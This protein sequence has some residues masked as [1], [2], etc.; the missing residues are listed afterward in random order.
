MQRESQANSQSQT[1]NQSWLYRLVNSEIPDIPD[2]FGWMER[3]FLVGFIILFTF[4]FVQTYP[5]IFLGFGLGDEFDWSLIFSFFEEVRAESPLLF[6]AALFALAANLLFRM[7]L[8]LRGQLAYGSNDPALPMKTIALYMLANSL[9]LLFIFLTVSLLGLLAVWLG[10][11]F[12]LGFHAVQNLFNLAMQHADQIPTVV[13][14]PLLIAFF[15]TYMVQGFFHYWIHRLC[16]LNRFLW[17]TLHRFHHM[18]PTLTPATTNVVITSVPFFIGIVFVKILIFSAISKLFYAEPLFMEMFFFHLLITFADPYGHQSALFKE[19]IRSRWIPKLCFCTSNGV[20]HYL[21]HSRDD[22]IVTSNKTNQVN[23]SGGLFFFWDHVFGT[24]KG[25]PSV[26][27]PK[28]EVGLWGNPDLHHNPIRLLMSGLV[29]IIY[30]VYYNKGFGTKLMCVLGS[31]N[32]APPI[33]RHFHI[34]ENHPHS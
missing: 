13:Q 7:Q 5:T 20:Y 31:V 4:I 14:L 33:T 22:A 10:F 6:Y 30:E 26:E 2:R 9:N 11:D 28:P 16:H 21:H 12:N 29:Q 3:L 17:L 1:R 32:Y 27:D 18:P 34:S 24:F 19:G 23:I 15:A 25:L 8:F